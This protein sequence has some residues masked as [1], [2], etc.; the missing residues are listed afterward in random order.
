MGVVGSLGGIVFEVSMDRVRTFDS[1][2]R[3]GSGRWET[4]DIIGKKPLSEFAGPGQEQISFSIRLD[5]FSGLNPQ[6]ELQALRDM[7]DTGEASVLVIG[8]EPMTDNLW[9][10][11]ALNEE[12][13]TFTGDGKLLTAVVDLTLKEYV[14]EAG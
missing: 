8:G 3:G 14:R 7:R 4:H 6:E 12:H 1:F 9:Y 10:L 2:K 5:A 11:E 13:K